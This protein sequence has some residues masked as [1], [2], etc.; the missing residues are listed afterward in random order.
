MLFEQYNRGRKRAIDTVS[1]SEMGRPRDISVLEMGNG[2][3]D[4]AFDY[5]SEQNTLPVMT[6]DFSTR[7]KTGYGP[8][9]V[10]NKAHSMICR[11]GE[12]VVR[13]LSS[14]ASSPCL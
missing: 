5:K 2:L 3:Y 1:Y 8:P 12:I 9:P 4:A 13:I 7:V 14:G 6:V 11:S 10:R